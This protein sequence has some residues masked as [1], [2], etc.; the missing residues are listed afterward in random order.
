MEI[1]EGAETVEVVRDRAAESFVVKACM[2]VRRNQ[3]DPRGGATLPVWCRGV[4]NFARA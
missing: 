2:T 3:R 1:T 4:Q